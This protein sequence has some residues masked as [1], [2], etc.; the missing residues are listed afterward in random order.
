MGACLCVCHFL[1]F[2]IQTYIYVSI[3]GELD[4]TFYDITPAC[5]NHYFEAI[6]GLIDQRHTI[7]T[8]AVYLS[9]ATIEYSRVCVCVCVCVFAR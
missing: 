5:F 2:L 1:A 4:P 6:M 7:L 3:F 9:N 8:D